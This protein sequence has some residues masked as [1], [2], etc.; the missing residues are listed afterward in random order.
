MSLGSSPPRSKPGA[1]RPEAP[2]RSPRAIQNCQGHAGKGTVLSGS[3]FRPVS[4]TGQLEYHGGRQ[5]LWRFLPQQLVYPGPGRALAGDFPVAIFWIR[6]RPKPTSKTPRPFPRPQ[7]GRV[8]WSRLLQ[9]SAHPGSSRPTAGRMRCRVR[10]FPFP[11]PT[12][13]IHPFHINKASFGK[14]WQG[15][16]ENSLPRWI[17]DS[18]YPQNC[19]NG[20]SPKHSHTVWSNILEASDFGV[21]ARPWGKLD[22]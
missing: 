16:L 1:S 20:W 21:G 2:S 22:V 15:G 13:S 4:R 12:P 5:A 8:V 19:E 6:S 9:V 3:R 11:V 10:P 18:V 14:S 7:S 17:F